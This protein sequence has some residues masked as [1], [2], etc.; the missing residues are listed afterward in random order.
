MTVEIVEFISM[1][2]HEYFLKRGNVEYEKI[3]G[4]R[5]NYSI[6]YCYKIL[7]KLYNIMHFNIHNYLY[8]S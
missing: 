3:I 1:S 7:Y 2:M 5:K 8:C 4:K 6:S